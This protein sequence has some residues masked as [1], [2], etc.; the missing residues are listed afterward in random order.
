[1]SNAGQIFSGAA[2]GWPADEGL[3]TLRRRDN[4]AACT[5]LALDFNST[6]VTD[7]GLKELA[8]LKQ[9]Q[10]L[11]LSFIIMTDTGLKELQKEL[12]G[13]GIPR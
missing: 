4:H 10:S 13:C 12:P 11:Y 3:H 2:G 1:M 9:L 5:W 8:V 6:E 7:A